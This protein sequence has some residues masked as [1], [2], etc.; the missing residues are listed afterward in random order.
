MG[1]GGGGAEL[2]LLSSGHP[3]DG[4]SSLP[5]WHNPSPATA[6]QGWALRSSWAR[7]EP[8]LSPCLRARSFGKT[9]GFA[10]TSAHLLSRQPRGSPGLAGDGSHLRRQGAPGAGDLHTYSP[11][12]L[13]KGIL[14]DIPHRG[15]TDV[16][17]IWPWVVAG[18]LIFLL[19]RAAKALRVKDLQRFGET[20]LS[21]MRQNTD[22]LGPFIIIPLPKSLLIHYRLSFS[23]V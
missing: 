23:L 3:R 10:G 15:A 22:K 20:G 16:E 2:Q 7:P 1:V 17:V 5:P 18:G 19:L 11:G 9:E 6:R 4:L 8:L 21:F 12:H 14:I 13:A